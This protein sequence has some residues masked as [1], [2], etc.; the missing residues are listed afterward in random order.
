MPRLLRTV[1]GLERLCRGH[2]LGPSSLKPGQEALR[3]LAGL[4]PSPTL[5]LPTE[6]QQLQGQNECRA[7]KRVR[8]WNRRAQ[9]HLYH[10]FPCCNRQQAEPSCGEKPAMPNPEDQAQTK[11]LSGTVGRRP[12]LGPTESERSP[13]VPPCVWLRFALSWPSSSP[14]GILRSPPTPL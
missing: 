7:L 9:D 6:Q 11:S 12:S 1:S 5:G 13:A 14:V 3:K 2:V 4:K 8:P 10:L